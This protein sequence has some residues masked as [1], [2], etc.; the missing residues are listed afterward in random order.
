MFHENADY[1]NPLLHEYCSILNN[2]ATGLD[3][4]FP[5]SF[6]LCLITVMLRRPESLLESIRVDLNHVF[7]LSLFNPLVLFE[8]SYIRVKL[9]N[10]F[11]YASLFI[12]Y[13]IN[14]IIFI[15]YYT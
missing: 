2:P 14:F 15:V 6:F 1:P 4:F 9:C 5:V 12:L 11:W 13:A 3:A 10:Y 8:A 7:N